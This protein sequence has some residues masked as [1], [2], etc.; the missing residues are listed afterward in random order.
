MEKELNRGRMVLFLKDNIKMEE[1]KV[2][3]HLNGMM[4]Q[5]KY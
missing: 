3:E 1:N 5:C 2:R 4:D